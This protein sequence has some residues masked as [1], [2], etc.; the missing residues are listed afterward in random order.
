MADRN[1]HKRQSQGI[2]HVELSARIKYASGAPQFVEG[3][4]VGAITGS[5][6]KM[7]QTGTGVL[8][9]TTTNPYP[10]FVGMQYGWSLA[11]PTGN[12]IS[13]QGKPSQNSD[14]TWSITIN[15]YT[16]AGGTHSAA[17]PLNGDEIHVTIILR[18]STV[19]P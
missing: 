16:N 8:T 10:G 18:N 14:G 15:T 5:Y 2:Q 4:T 12:S 17:T 13:N 3:D 1:F 6:L 11:T 9:I 19:L 7:V